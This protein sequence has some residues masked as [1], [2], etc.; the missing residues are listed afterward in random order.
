MRDDFTDEVKRILAARVNYV[1]SNPDC[2]AQTTGPQDDPTK[3][4]NVG[5]AAHITGASMGGPRYNPGLSPDERRHS[6]NG[7]WLCQNCAKLVDS[8]VQRFDEKLLRAWKTVAEDRARNSLGKTAHAVVER[9]SPNLELYLEFQEIKGDTY[10]PRTTPVRVFV[11]GLKNGVGCG[12]AKFPSIRYKRACG[13]TVDHFGIDGC[14]GFGLPP[15]PS[16]KE[17]ETFRGGSNHVIHPGETLK[18][19]KLIQHGRNIGTKWVF[20]A[21]TFECEISAEGIPT[22][23]V[24]K[25]LPGDT[26]P[27]P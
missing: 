24:E 13:L 1:C 26:A 15:S 3:A 4:V 16:E 9:P 6:D 17:W 25:E 27:W 5:V 23:T 11:M 10:S 21:V 2:R 19:A 12:T 8:D 7:I 22:I 14:R 20:D 18:I